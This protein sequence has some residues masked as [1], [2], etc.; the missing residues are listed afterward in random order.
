MLLVK[1][2]QNQVAL[3]DEIDEDLLK[4]KWYAD[5][6]SSYSN[7]GNFQAKRNSRKSESKRFTTFRMHRII[8]ERMLGRK[9]SSDEDVD[10]INHNPLDNRRSNLRL[11]S[12][13][14]NCQNQMKR[15]TNTSGYKGVHYLKRE[16]KWRAR[17]QC[18]GKR[19]LLGDFETAELAAC[20]Y[21]EKAK[22]LFG[23]FALTN[24]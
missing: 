20:A 13:S 23:K 3:I 18:K 17:I 4:F 14:Q 10:H 22:E 6:S 11:A 8:L 24:F 2:T 5:Y 15:S 21:D 7:G 9:L 12:R 1:L 19:L 16:G